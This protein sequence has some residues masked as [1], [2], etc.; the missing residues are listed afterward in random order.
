VEDFI[1]NKNKPEPFNTTQDRTV[2]VL[3]FSL[4]RHCIVEVIRFS[5]ARHCI[6]G[7][8]YENET[9][10]MWNSKLD[11]LDFKLPK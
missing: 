10:A 3:C 11:E 4:A 7:K 2:N 8:Y 5:L 6:E 1:T 9:K